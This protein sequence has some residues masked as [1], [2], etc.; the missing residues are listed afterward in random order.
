MMVIKSDVAVAGHICLDIIPDLSTFP[1]KDFGT[2]F[3]PGFLL[4]IGPAK[5]ALGG[6]VANTGL[7]LHILGI[8]TRLMGKVGDDLF[9]HAVLDIMESY[10]KGMSSAMK[11]DKSIPTSYT[12]VI[13][14]PNVDR[15]FMHCPGAND[16]F[17]VDD[18]RYDL[19]EGT[20]LFHF[21]YPPAMKKM[22][23]DEGERLREI[24]QRAKS[25]SEITSMDTALPDPQ[26]ASGK[27]D[28]S[29]IFKKTL[30]YVDVFLPSI[31]ELLFMI[32]RDVYDEMMAKAKAGDILPFIE[33]E[34]LMSLADQLHDWGAKIAVIKLGY[35]GLFIHTAGKEM[36]SGICKSLQT[37]I[38]IWSTK[39]IWAPIF[40]VNVVGTTGSGDSTI[41]G[42]LSALLRGYSPEDAAVA[43]TAVGACNVEAADSLSGL[44]S[45]EETMERINQG[46]E[47]VPLKLDSKDWLYD[48]KRCI[49]IKG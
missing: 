47:R 44:R 20:K 18:I 37:D 39:G 43:A 24:Y 36:M 46:W 4:L 13:N 7:A 22:Y 5:I 34:L 12:F 14:P 38:G 9:G 48:E 27:A 49:W 1:Q 25:I 32:K 17:D 45:W 15:F 3:R 2:V 23:D 33:P 30:P 6:P 35:R 28:W 21:G 42:F 40:K 31:E 26:S 29:L 8:K 11:M 10:Q 41:A 19:L 16:T